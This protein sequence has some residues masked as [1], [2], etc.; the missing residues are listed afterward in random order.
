MFGSYDQ[1]PPAGE[2]GSV[3]AEE[4]GQPGDDPAGHSGLRLAQ[5]GNAGGAS[6]LVVDRA[7][8]TGVVTTIVYLS[9]TI[10]PVA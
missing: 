1:H 5:G 4:I 6:R 2:A 3:G 8:R 10:Q 7:A 9:I